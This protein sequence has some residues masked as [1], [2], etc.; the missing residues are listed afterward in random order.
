MKFQVVSMGV[1]FCP[2]AEAA[3]KPSREVQAKGTGSS[4]QNRISSV[5]S[6]GEVAGNCGHAK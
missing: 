6:I 5:R 2:A 3:S 1:L 4:G